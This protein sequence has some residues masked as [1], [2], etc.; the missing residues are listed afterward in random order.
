M[1]TLSKW[2]IEDQTKNQVVRASTIK[3][4]LDY[5]TKIVDETLEILTQKRNECNKSNMQLYKQSDGA[6]E[7]LRKLQ[8]RVE[9]ELEMLYAI[10]SLR[11]IRRSLDSI[12]GLGNVSTM[13]SPTISIVRVIRSRMLTLAPVIDFQ[14][15]ELSLLISGVIIDAAHL[16]GS[17]LDF[18]VANGQSRRLL[19]EAKLIADSKINKLFPNLDLQ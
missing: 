9:D 16:A 2:V 6:V 15:G 17:T 14:L 8:R 18:E 13:M 1:A 11:Q 7:S 3:P 12:V 19:D 5:A 4:R 10:E